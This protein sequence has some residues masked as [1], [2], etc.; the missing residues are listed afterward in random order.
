MSVVEASEAEEISDPSVQY[1]S[2]TNPAEEG[3]V[4][5]SGTAENPLTVEEE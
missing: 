3:E 5:T 2:S 1:L 4:I